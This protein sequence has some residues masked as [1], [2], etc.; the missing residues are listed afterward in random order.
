LEREL[1]HR[2]L[3][4]AARSRDRAGRPA[5]VLRRGDGSARPRDGPRPLPDPETPQ[6]PH[7]DRRAH[8]SGRGSRRVN[9]QRHSI[10][11]AYS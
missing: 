3:R 7:H 11:S 8:V 10:H 1:G 4:P 6:S 9:P 2:L 5:R